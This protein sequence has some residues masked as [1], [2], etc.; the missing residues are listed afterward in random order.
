MK[1]E[2]A[3]GRLSDALSMLDPMYV[4]E[5]AEMPAKRRQV[6]RS[7][8]MLIKLLPA[9]CL[10]VLIAVAIFQMHVRDHG[11]DVVG[12]DPTSNLPPTQSNEQQG[13]EYT[14]IEILF[15]WQDVEHLM[16]FE[17]TQG[18]MSAAVEIAVEK[19]TQGKYAPYEAGYVI[20][21]SCVGERLDTVTVKTYWYFVPQ[22]TERDVIYIGAEVYAIQG[23]SPEA[24]VCLRYTEKGVANTTTHYYI[25]SNPTWH[26]ASLEAF[27]EAFDMRTH[28]AMSQSVAYLYRKESEAISTDATRVKFNL[29][30]AERAELRAMLLSL[31]GEARTVTNAQELD[32]YIAQSTCQAQLIVRANTVANR[33]FAI[34]VFNNGYLMIVQGG[35][36]MLFEIGRANAEAI[37]ERIGQA[38]QYQNDA[39]GD[40]VEETVRY[41]PD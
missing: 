33:Y 2:E 38:E 29:N 23:V 3:R 21:A 6:W 34:Q 36:P 5:A 16:G 24:A 13:E 18:E 41:S 28:L 19:I 11:G 9:A 39:G 1:N 15:P 12:S 27:Y 4:E 8:S 37:I 25:Y 30:E 22:K 26:G 40:A 7:R 14:E 32:A 17:H 31:T 10:F 20:D 35:S